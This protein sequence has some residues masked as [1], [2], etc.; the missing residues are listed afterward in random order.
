M[1]SRR[2]VNTAGLVILLAIGASQFGVAPANAAAACGGQNQ[3]TCKVW[4]RKPACKPGL[5]LSLIH[6]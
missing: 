5:K 4:D 6:I 3:R 2:T 1:Y